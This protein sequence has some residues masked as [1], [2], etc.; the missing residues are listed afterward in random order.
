VLLQSDNEQR[1]YMCS[2]VAEPAVKPA[3]QPVAK[4]EIA[5]GIGGAACC[6]GYCSKAKDGKG[7]KSFSSCIEKNRK[8]CAAGHMR[9][10]YVHRAM[11]KA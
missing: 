5:T 9:F 8:D 6:A 10:I 11:H 1:Y 2:D 3:V 7:P 4:R